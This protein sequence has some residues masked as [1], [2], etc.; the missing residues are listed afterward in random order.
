MKPPAEN[1]TRKFDKLI[2]YELAKKVI[3]APKIEV[4]AT[5][6]FD[7]RAFDFENPLYNR[8]PKS[9]ISCGISCNMTASVVAMPNGI[10]TT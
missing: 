7:N 8:T 4:K 3:R 1:G 9:P 2:M 5:K 6:K 10:D